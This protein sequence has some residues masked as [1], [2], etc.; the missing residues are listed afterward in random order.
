MGNTLF[1]EI[2]FKKSKFSVLTEIWFLD[3]FEY[4]EFNGAVHFFCFILQTPFTK[5]L[6]GVKKSTII[7]SATLRE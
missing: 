2:W 3:W 4:G 6:N 7:V 5:T 1:E